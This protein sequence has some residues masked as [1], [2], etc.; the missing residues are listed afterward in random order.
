MAVL[1]RSF[2]LALESTLVKL[3]RTPDEILQGRL[4]FTQLPWQLPPIIVE[5]TLGGRKLQEYFDEPMT[6]NEKAFHTF[7]QAA[8]QGLMDKPEKTFGLQGYRH[9][10]GVTRE[11]SGVRLLR[12]SKPEGFPQKITDYAGA[13]LSLECAHACKVAGL[14]REFYD[15]DS[16]Y[17]AVTHGGYEIGVRDGLPIAGADRWDTNVSGIVQELLRMPRGDVFYGCDYDLVSRLRS[18]LHE[19][20]NRLLEFESA[21]W[22]LQAMR[23]LLRGRHSPSL[24]RQVQRLETTKQVFGARLEALR[25]AVALVEAN[26]YSD[27]QKI[28]ILKE[29][30]V[31]EYLTRGKFSKHIYPFNAPIPA[32][33]NQHALWRIKGGIGELFR[34]EEGLHAN[35]I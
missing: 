11:H 4:E 14:A 19:E 20:K 18:F 1:E 27:R 32:V 3:G 6:F 30:L 10:I 21:D 34:I 31:P 12:F 29:T 23:V 9:L 26:A 33:L 8:M 5:S 24:L 25:E 16:D 13:I 7:W 2:A 35:K 28:Q 15:T 22:A 17:W